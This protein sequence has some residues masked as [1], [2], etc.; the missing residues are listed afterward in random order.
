M[1]HNEDVPPSFAPKNRNNPNPRNKNNDPIIVGKNNPIQ[2]SSNRSNISKNSKANNTYN[3]SNINS[4]SSSI[5]PSYTPLSQRRNKP[6]NYEARNISSPRKA[7][8]FRSTTNKDN[9]NARQEPKSYAPRLNR[10]SEHSAS[11]TSPQSNQYYSN[12]QSPTNGVLHQNL[13]KTP[14]KKKVKRA[15]ISVLTI[16]ILICVVWPS[17]L[18]YRANSQLNTVEAIS[19]MAKTSEG[20]TWLIAGSD[21]RSDSHIQDKTEGERSDSIILV[22]KA[23][24]GQASMISLPRDTLA[25]IPGYDLDKLNSSFSYGGA[26]L[27]VKTVEGLTNTKID[28]YVQI[29]MSGVENL[30]N[31]VNGVNLC[32]NYDVNDRLSELVWKSGCHDADGKTALAFAR[33]RYSDPL[34]D[35]GRADRQRQVVSKLMNKVFTLPV[36]LNPFTQLALV[37]AGS[38]SVKTDQNT[39]SY[40]IGMLALAFRKARN[41]NI[42][43]VPPIRSLNY[44]L[45][46]GAS[47]VLLDPDKKDNFFNKMREGSL[48]PDDFEKFGG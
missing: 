26:K 41:D 7:P 1:N 28:H 48:T 3:P 32:L 14:T 9:M 42:S 39:G 2:H 33:M 19:D 15:L 27:L 8:V 24:N 43:G 44:V 17:Y 30:V 34:G 21:S 31:A 18:F 16:L 38:Q 4:N 10:N 6:T 37:D 29:G 46:S 35:I 5:P 40:D 20:T 45:L 22:H 36:M 12:L 13:K 47:T 25:R 11:N 23:P